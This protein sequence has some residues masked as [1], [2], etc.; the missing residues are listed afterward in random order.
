MVPT[1]HK[2]S[3]LRPSAWHTWNTCK[4]LSY[5]G[6]R[7]IRKYLTLGLH[8]GIVAWEHYIRTLEGCIRDFA[9]SRIVLSGF[10]RNWILETTTLGPFF[11]LSTFPDL[12]TSLF[13]VLFIIS[14]LIEF[15][16][17]RTGVRV[18]DLACYSLPG[19]N[20]P[21]FPR[22]TIV[23]GIIR[24]PRATFLPGVSARIELGRLS[25]NRARISREVNSG[26]S[27][28][29]LLLLLNNF[30]ISFGEARLLLN[31]IIPFNRRDGWNPDSF[32]VFIRSVTRWTSGVI[33]SRPTLARQV[34]MIDR[35]RPSEG[36]RSRLTWSSF[37]WPAIIT[38]NG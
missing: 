30:F 27:S 13:V 32:R 6:S 5:I 38:V 12:T 28:S 9:Q 15:S 17:E 7:K 37:G 34:G 19:R 33:R 1:G 23:S 10:T 22:Q 36:S 20:A 8:I 24:R 2:K 21:S 4:E 29:L 11:L 3:S 18:C 31:S 26:F 16:F 35:R 25:G 14:E